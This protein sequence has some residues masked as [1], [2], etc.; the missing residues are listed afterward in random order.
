MPRER[1]LATLSGGF[2]VLALLLAAVGLYGV[3][4]YSVSRRGREIGIRMA[5]GARRGNV[6]WPLAAPPLSIRSPPS[7][8]NRNPR[9]RGCAIK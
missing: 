2:A 8:R 6:L 5:L 1:L 7:G 9:A 4:S 3:M